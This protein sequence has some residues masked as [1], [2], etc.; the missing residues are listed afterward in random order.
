[1]SIIDVIKVPIPK[2]RKQMAKPS[3]VIKNPKKELM[4]NM[5]RKSKNNNNIEY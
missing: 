4:K 1:M 5:C 2:Q 3:K